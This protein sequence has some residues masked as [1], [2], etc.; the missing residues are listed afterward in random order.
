MGYDA[1]VLKSGW[2]EYGIAYSRP[3]T[4]VHIR[5]VRLKSSLGAG[6]A[7]CSEMSGGISN[8]LA[9][10]LHLRDSFTGIKIKASKGRGGYVKYILISDVIMVNVQ[11]ALEATGQCES[12]PDDKFDPYALP[13][14]KSITFKDI[15]G[16][17]ITTAGMF[18]GISES[19]FT[20]ICLLNISLSISFD[21]FDPSTIWV[22]SNVSGFSE[23]VSPEPCPDLQESFPN[24]SSACFFLLCPRS[25]VAIL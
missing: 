23:A 1:I 16:T 24:S 20:S 8:V 12:H 7:F 25:R 18:L 11:L 2:D 17:N 22:C 5:D 4:N 19:P 13:I 3:T 21:S 10:H 15:V 14:V 9:E 6:L